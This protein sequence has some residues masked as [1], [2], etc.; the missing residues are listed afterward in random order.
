MTTLLGPMLPVL[1]A[2]WALDDTQAGY[3]FTAQFA[4]SMAGVSLSGS[5]TQRYGYR[6]ALV[7]GLGV[8]ATGAAVLARSSWAAGIAAVCCYGF[9]IGVVSPAANLL[10][11]ELNP[12]NR[13]AALNWLNF[14]WG[15]GAVGFPLGVA[16]LALSHRTSL[17]M[18]GMASMLLLTALSLSFAPFA[19]PKR[20]RAEQR[21]GGGSSLGR[22]WFVFL[23]GSLFF[24]YVGTENCIGGWTASYAH[25]MTTVHGTFWALTPSFFWGA[26]LAGRALAPGFLRHMG[27]RHLASAGL[28]IASCG[29]SVLLAARTIG[30]VSLGAVVAGLGLASVFPIDIALLAELFGEMASRAGGIMFALAALGGATLPW[31]VGLVSTRFGNLK[32][33]LAVSLLSCLMMLFLFYLVGRTSNEDKDGE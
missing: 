28:L 10:I 31:L 7:L 19:M 2:R 23:L 12:S 29:V 22:N 11:A 14:S 32:I 33:G 20:L 16:L 13:A 4:S 21:D 26:L 9:G 8:M 18:V 6:V 30:V 25:R 3:L 5:A 27:E 1:S 17:L 24:L 15:I